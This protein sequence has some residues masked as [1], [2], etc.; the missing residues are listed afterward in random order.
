MADVAGVAVG[1]IG[2]AAL[3]K[4]VIDIIDYVDLGSNFERD[5][6]TCL[7]RLEDTRVRL[8]RWAEAAGVRDDTTARQRLGSDYGNAEKHLQHIKLRFEDAQKL[9]EN[10]VHGLESTQL[11]AIEQTMPPRANRIRTTY[12]KIYEPVRRLQKKTTWAL[13]GEKAFNRL[14]FDT[15][16][17]VQ[18]LEALVPRQ[19][20]RSLVE[21]ELEEINNPED[22]LALVTATTLAEDCN[23]QPQDVILKDVAEKRFGHSFLNIQNSDTAQ[24]NMGDFI[25][26]DAAT[27]GVTETG[28]THQYDGVKNTGKA[29]VFMGN[30]IGAQKSY[31][32]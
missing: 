10:Y 9:S 4:S 11:G 29:K 16:S 22:V 13:R 2:L 24:V 12:R 26:A 21:M 1:V 3:F 17:L 6:E 20:L 15:D 23:T 18:G 19:D 30:T 25:M 8:Y 5:Y 28:R 7:L 27:A 14:I 31:W 32:D